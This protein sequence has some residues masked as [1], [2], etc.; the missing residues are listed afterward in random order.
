MVLKS[1]ITRYVGLISQ[2][3]YHKPRL[4][5]VHWSGEVVSLGERLTS[6][7]GGTLK[8]RGAESVDDVD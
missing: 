4:S 7:L 6:V 5:G 1:G 2:S 8:D 3:M